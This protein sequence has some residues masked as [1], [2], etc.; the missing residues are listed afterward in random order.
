MATAARAGRQ[1]RKKAAVSAD[2]IFRR[3]LAQA[4]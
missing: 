4:V 1:L 2:M 3:R